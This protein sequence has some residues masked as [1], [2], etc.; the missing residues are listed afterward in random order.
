MSFHSDLDHSYLDTKDNN[1]MDKRGLCHQRC[2]FR[3]SNVETSP[4]SEFGDGSS[5]SDDPGTHGP[6]T[7]QWKEVHVQRLN[8]EVVRVQLPI[9][10]C[11][12]PTQ[13]PFYFCNEQLKAILFQPISVGGVVLQRPSIVENDVIENLHTQLADDPVLE[14]IRI[15]FDQFIAAD[16]KVVQGG[17][18]LRSFRQQFRSVT[19]SLAATME[20][21][22]LS[23][24]TITDIHDTITL[25]KVSQISHTTE[26]QLDEIIVNVMNLILTK[27]GLGQQFRISSRSATMVSF[28]VCGTQMSSSTSVLLE[29]VDRSHTADNLERIPIALSA[30]KSPQ[31]ASVT[32]KGTF[33]EMSSLMANKT[34]A[35]HP[36]ETSSVHKPSTSTA[37][38]ER[39]PPTSTTGHAPVFAT[40]CSM[41]PSESVYRSKTTQ[42]RSSRQSVPN[43][44]IIAQSVS[45]AD[46][47]PFETDDFKITY[48]ISLVGSTRIF[49]SRTHSSKSTLNEMKGQ[50]EIISRERL[51][52][53]YTCFSSLDVRDSPFLC[54]QYLYMAFSYLIKIF[55]QHRLRTDSL[56]ED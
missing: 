22:A 26:H 54:F 3:F 38:C 40:A 50:C 10:R 46:R 17:D 8:F 33:L 19:A 31:Q 1:K 25:I 2:L 7:N 53:S 55:H 20:E 4:P 16:E 49:I 24:E 23:H 14:Y 12:M 32:A 39:E 45:M 18:E 42:P 37:T 56:L 47:T 48:H 51:A 44:D 5:D 6:S 35:T 27:E 30:N 41:M 9:E 34:L 52:K 13:G 43:T 36:S 15:L 29:Y 11:I 21:G 28:P